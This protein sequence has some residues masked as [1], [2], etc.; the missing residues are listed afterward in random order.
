M[1]LAFALDQIEARDLA[2]ITNYGEYLER[3]PPIHRVEIVEDTSWSCMHGI[4][5]WRSDCGC[6]SGGRQSWNQEWRAPLRQALDWLRDT[7]AS[8][9]QEK[10]LQLLSDPWAARDDYIDVILDRSQDRVDRFLRSHAARE[11]NAADRVTALKLLE[12][13]RH[14]MLMYTSCGWFFDEL[15]GI[16]TIQCMQYAG[17]VVDLSRQL[18]TDDLET[19]FV[20]MLSQAKSNLA[21]YGDGAQLYHKWVRPSFVDLR[22]VAAHYAIASL[23]EPSTE[24]QR[25]YCYGVQR[26]DYTVRQREQTK[27]ATGRIRIWSTITTECAP[28][29]FVVLQLGDHQIKVRVGDPLEEP[30]HQAFVG[31]LSEALVDES[32]SEIVQRLDHLFGSDADS[33]RS[34]FKDEQRAF[35]EWILAPLV[36]EAEAAHIRLYDRNADLMRFLAERQIPLPKT[37]RA[38]AEFALNYQ[39]RKE[40]LGEGPTLQR[41][42]PLIDEAR[43]IN[44]SL[45]LS[46]LEFALRN[47]LEQMAEGLSD[48][49]SDPVL[50]HRFRAAVELAR[51]LPFP[52]NLWQVQNI[53][54]EQLRVLAGKARGGTRSASETIVAGDLAQLGETLLFTAQALDALLHPAPAD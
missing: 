20:E 37:F 13:Q 5:R 1:T 52:V 24:L 4:A 19:P 31:A 6:N 30:A 47:R 2:K 9:Y 38:S 28:L 35:L 48:C 26:E 54:Y 45:D 33:L 12:M 15:S 29:A 8:R 18:F 50:C 51:S 25:V 39:L 16:E 49:L 17:R 40:F 7:V 42:A 27:L 10:A 11:L 32:A 21:E 46:T 43:A 22:Q 23:L 14:A 44:V 41:V 34:L 36:A 53:F 3:H